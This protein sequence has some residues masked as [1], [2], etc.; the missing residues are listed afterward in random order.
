MGI[1]Q[2]MMGR[3]F[4]RLLLA[5]MALTTQSVLAQDDLTGIWEGM[6]EIA[7][8][9]GI[10]MH[11][12]FVRDADGQLTATVSSPE[13]P[14][15]QNLPVEDVSFEGGGLSLG[16][17]AL[18]GSFAGRLTDGVVTGSWTQPG[19]TV[20]LTLRPYVEPVLTAADMERILGSWVGTLR[21]N[22]DDD[23]QVTVVFRFERDA[24]GEFAAFMDSPD[25][26]TMGI[27]VDSV[28]MIN[29][30]LT[31]SVNRARMEFIGTLDGDA[32]N[33][34]WVQASRS[35]ELN[36]TRGEYEAA[37]LP[38]S[39]E[40]F[41]RLEGPWHGQIGPLNLVFR[42]ERTASGRFAAF[43]DSQDQGA[44]NIPITQIQ[45]DGDQLTLS[46]A[47]IGGSLTGTLA[48]DSIDAQWQ[49][50]G[51][52]SPIALTRG[53]YVPN[54]DLTADA[55]RYLQGT[56][57]GNVTGADLV[58]RFAATADGGF[59]TFLD[60]AS[61]GMINVPVS[62]VALEGQSLRFQINAIDARFVGALSGG[63]I[64]GTWTRLDEDTQITL[65]RD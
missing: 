7:P 23:L 5:M 21:P 43:F 35:L 37:G 12:N 36:L 20:P 51:Q 17:A 60:I 13:Q 46:A 44:S 45:L 61:V 49:Q 57:R 59:D 30:E 10:E 50:A 62:G 34:D 48:Q 29:D 47:V 53:P 54:P 26:G 11:F 63:Q 39:E 3:F 15:L 22:P 52:Q 28:G 38:L 65:M 14:A 32:L 27:P 33:G 9:Q 40:Q 6:L 25:E 55:Q 31:L 58:F 24:Q 56:W 2:G 41:A 19:S 4:T 18:S 42:F 64:T 8:G 16:V 1:V